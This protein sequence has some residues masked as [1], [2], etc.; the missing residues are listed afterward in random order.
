MVVV[1][2][3]EVL[4]HE[5]GEPGVVEEEVEHLGV[6]PVPAGYEVGELLAEHEFVGVAVVVEGDDAQLLVSG[7]VESLLLE[8]DLVGLGGAD[9]E[10]L[11]ESLDQG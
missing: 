1:A 10:L 4:D 3:T 5:L 2:L 6:L 7:D 11:V 9:A 8:P